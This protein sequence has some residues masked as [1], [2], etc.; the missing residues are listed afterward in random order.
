MGIYRHLFAF[1]KYMPIDPSEYQ[2]TIVI[3][4]ALFQE[5]EWSNARK[6]EIS[7]QW[8]CIVI[9]IY[10]GSLAMSGLNVAV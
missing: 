8:F 5:T 9:E 1:Q 10:Q 4:A 6:R 2:L 3:Y 7:R